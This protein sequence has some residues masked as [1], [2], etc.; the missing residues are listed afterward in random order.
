MAHF[1]FQTI[2][3]LCIE[4]LIS[5]RKLLIDTDSAM[6]PFSTY[7]NV[8]HIQLLTE[9]VKNEDAAWTEKIRG[10]NVLIAIFKKIKTRCRI[11]LLPSFIVIPQWVAI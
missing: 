4:G 2:S 8:F 5:D 7:F 3:V 11:V 6:A 1:L 9:A 10:L